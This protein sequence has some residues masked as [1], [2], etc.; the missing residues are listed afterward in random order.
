MF[1]NE[2]LINLPV[3]SKDNIF[4]GKIRSFEI[5]EAQIIIKYYVKK[6]LFKEDLIIHRNQVISLDKEKMIVESGEEKILV[7]ELSPTI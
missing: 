1:K 3:F 2:D 5:D 4:L 6:G 7:K